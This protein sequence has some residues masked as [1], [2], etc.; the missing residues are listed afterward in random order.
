MFALV[1]P[2]ALA[3]A[4]A[5]SPAPVTRSA[6]ETKAAPAAKGVPATKS[7]PGSKSAKSAAA[8]KPLPLIPWWE[9]I[10]VTMDGEGKTKS[11]KYESSTQSQPSDDC[12]LFGNMTNAGDGDAQTPA[13][14]R[15][16]YTTLTFERRFSPGVAVPSD[17]PLATG[18]MLLGR[19]IMALAIDGHGRVSNCKVVATSGDLPPDY[20]CNDASAERFALTGKSTGP[21]EGFFTIRIYGHSEHVVIRQL[22]PA[23]V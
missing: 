14:Q 20:N 12:A 4:P 23:R 22:S 1:A 17:V 2:F 19:E 8:N 11:C 15:N 7:A 21:R 16:Q 3:A 9:K 10:T 5:A 18:D 6:P 13:S